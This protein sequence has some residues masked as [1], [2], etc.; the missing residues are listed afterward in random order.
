MNMNN[1]LK[2][3]KRAIKIMLKLNYAESTKT[4]IYDPKESEV[5]SFIIFQEADTS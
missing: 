1:S 3:Q 2:Q 5:C 4:L